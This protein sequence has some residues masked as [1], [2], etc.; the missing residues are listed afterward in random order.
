MQEREAL[1]PSRS[2]NKYKTQLYRT[3]RHE[4]GG[5]CA[6]QR[7]RV[8]HRITTEC[9]LNETRTDFNCITQPDQCSAKPLKEIAR[10]R[11][12]VRSEVTQPGVFAFLALNAARR[13]MRQSFRATRWGRG[14]NADEQRLPP[15][16][17]QYSREGIFLKTLS[18]QK[19]RKRWA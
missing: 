4:R 11:I 8:T 3:N 17:L 16:D 9:M 15:K 18:A 7:C 1:S 2:L 12:Q 13:R 14:K 19:S 10:N 5:I 6:R